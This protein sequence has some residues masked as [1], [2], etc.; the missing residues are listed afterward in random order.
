MS[1]KNPNQAEADDK[2]L[3]VECPYCHAAIGE[4]CWI[5][6]AKNGKPQEVAYVPH[7]HRVKEAWRRRF[8]KVNRNGE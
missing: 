6:K 8:Q 1:R 4:P 7:R 5:L 3:K 2:A